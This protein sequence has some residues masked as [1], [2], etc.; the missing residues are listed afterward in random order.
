MVA[1]EKGQEK[2]E[3]SSDLVI[4]KIEVPAN[5]YDCTTNMNLLHF[6]PSVWCILVV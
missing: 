3:G 2:A 4:Y 1:K 6:V 5:R